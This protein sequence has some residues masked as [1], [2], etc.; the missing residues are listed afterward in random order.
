MSETASASGPGSAPVPPEVEQLSTKLEAAAIV[1]A[2]VE[3]EQE[4]LEPQQSQ[5]TPPQPPTQ[6]TPNQSTPP[7]QPNVASDTPIEGDNSPP[8]LQSAPQPNIDGNNNNNNEK[9]KIWCRLL[10]PS[11]VAGAIIGKG[12]ATI[13]SLRDEFA[14]IINIPE[15]RAPERVLKICVTSREKLDLLISRIAEILKDEIMKSG[16]RRKEGETELR[17]L[18]Q[19]SQAGAIIGTKGSTVK[20]LREST[21]SRININPECCPNSTERVAAIMG[22]PDTVVKCISMIYDILEKVPPKG[23]EQRYDPNCFDQTY[24][25]GGFGYDPRSI[26]YHHPYHNMAPRFDQPGGHHGG[27]RFIQHQPY[28]Q[29]QGPTSGPNSNYPPSHGHQQTYPGRFQPPNNTPEFIP[30][31][32][33]GRPGNHMVRNFNPNN[34]RGGYGGNRGGPRGPR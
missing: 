17:I 33:S 34:Q 28:F 20:T 5:D 24:D 15:A 19:S 31:P 1:E 14:A 12:G 7:S 25:Y 26:G 8:A 23:S 10:I 22:R 3:P 30:S 29:P 4:A 27:P 16:I 9:N 21:G 2:P 32:Q 18:V 11:K 6:Q 13:K